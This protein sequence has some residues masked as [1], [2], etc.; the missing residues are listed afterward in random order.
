LVKQVL[1]PESTRV[2]IKAWAPLGMD[3]PFRV[4][5]LRSGAA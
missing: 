3:S 5:A 1:T 4:L 2:R